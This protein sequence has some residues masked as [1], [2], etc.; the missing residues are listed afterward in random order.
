VSVTVQSRLCGAVI[1]TLSYSNFE[2]IQLQRKE[3]AAK[4]NV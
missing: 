2:I 1:D 3:S 4:S